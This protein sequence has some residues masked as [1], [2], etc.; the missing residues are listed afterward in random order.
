MLARS[1][2]RRLRRDT[3][4]MQ[5]RPVRSGSLRQVV[6]VV[7]KNGTG[8]DREDQT[9]SSPAC[10][11]RLRSRVPMMTEITTLARSNRI[12]G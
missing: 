8:R 5:K 1:R 12:K 11:R 4:K 9:R 3:E 7:S 10:S 2:A 6:F